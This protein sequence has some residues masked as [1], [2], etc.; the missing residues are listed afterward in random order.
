MGVER[1]AGAKAMAKANQTTTAWSLVQDYDMSDGHFIACDRAKRRI[2]YIGSVIV[3]MRCYGLPP[4]GLICK[5]Y[6]GKTQHREMLMKNAKV[7]LYRPVP[8][9]H[10]ENTIQDSTN[11]CPHSSH[12]SLTMSSCPTRGA[13]Q[14]STASLASAS[15]GLQRVFRARN[16]CHHLKMTSLASLQ[17]GEISLVVSF[18]LRRWWS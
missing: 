17:S 2:K 6:H 14:V 9:G 18:L 10:K 11:C 15:V 16:R 3:V 12:R 7:Y 8:S 13:L 4:L 5:W 1:G